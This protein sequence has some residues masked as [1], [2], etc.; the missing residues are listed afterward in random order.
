MKREFDIIVIGGGHSGSEAAHAAAKLGCKTLLLTNNIDQ[1]ASMPCNPAIGGPAKSHLVKEIDALGG[2]MGLAADAT[3]LQ[4]KTLNSSKGPAVRA[5][6]AQSD[7]REY[8]A[9]VRQYLEQMQNLEIYQ[10]SA[11]ALIIENE[12]VVGLETKLEEQIYAKAVILTA[13]TFLEGRIFSG[14]KFESAGRAGE[15]PALELSPKLQDLGL[16]TGR[17]KTGTPPRIDKRTIDFSNLEIAPGDKELEWFSFLPDRPVRQ[18]YLCHITRTNAKTHE[19][20]MDNLNKSPMYSGLVE[21]SGPRYCPSIE[22][23]VVRFSHNPSHHFFLEPESLSSNEIYLQGCSTSLP[24]EVQWQMIRTLPGLEQAVITRPAYAVEY[25]YFPGIQ[26]KHSLESKTVSGLFV[27]G[28]V[29]GTSGYEEAAAQGLIAG[30]NATR[31]LVDQ[32][33]FILERSSSYIG[34]LI[35]DLVT[36][37]INDP[38]RMLTSRSEYRLI[39]R[40]DNADQRLTP[41]GRELGLVDD[42]RWA[43]FKAK[44]KRIDHELQFL[45]SVRVPVKKLDLDYK[46]GE[47]ILLADLLRRPDYD[48]RKLDL[49]EL[50]D[51]EN[52]E[53]NKLKDRGINIDGLAYGYE[54]DTLLKYDGYIERQSSQIEEMQKIDRIKIPADFDFLNCEVISLEAREKLAKVQPKTLGQASRV[55][56]VTPNDVSVLSMLLSGLKQP[57]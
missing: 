51:D 18:Q 9:W 4:M 42:Y 55:G 13:G 2:I 45:K 10:A 44:Q 23:K 20:I 19:I 39:L 33:A 7:K 16:K 38:Y 48:Y 49:Q 35:D 32:E 46:A 6:R 52:R 30:I 31:Y 54:V 26:F 22:D 53:A 11:K 41:I 56:G 17:L 36:K 14:D 12:K 37:E 28:Q 43:C 34:T 3:Y 21:A 50:V 15:Q 25:D 5:L 57:Q 40:Q 1:I 47:K 29:L 27:A 8:S 24:I